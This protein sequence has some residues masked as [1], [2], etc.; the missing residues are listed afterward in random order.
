MKKKKKSVKKTVKKT[1]KKKAKAK[2]KT[3]KSWQGVGLQVKRFEI[4]AAVPQMPCSAINKDLQGLT[5]CHTQATQ[6]YQIYR[7]EMM[8]RKMT[9]N[10]IECRTETVQTNESKDH[11]AFFSSRSH[12]TFRITDTESGEY[13]DIQST[14]LG[15]NDV[16]SDNSSQTVAMKQALLQ[17]FFTAWPQPA[18]HVEVVRSTLSKL[19]KDEFKKAVTSMLKNTLTTKGAVVALEDYFTKAGY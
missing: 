18:N 9:I 12:C 13:D 14:A 17:Y 19:G 5:Y 2:R 7:N 3:R 6:V 4:M 8:D 10:M 15:N 16:W 1:V 11:Q